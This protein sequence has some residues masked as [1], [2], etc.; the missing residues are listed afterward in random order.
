MTKRNN[1]TKAET[2]TA[3]E[4]TVFKTFIESK[5]FDEELLNSPA[6]IELVKKTAAAG[7]TPDELQKYCIQINHTFKSVIGSRPAREDKITYI[8][9]ALGTLKRKGQE[10]KQTNFEKTVIDLQDIL[11][12]LETNLEKLKFISETTLEGIEGRINLLKDDGNES[13]VQYSSL[14]AIL[15]ANNILSDYM[16][17]ISIDLE[18]AKE[19]ADRLR[20]TAKT[21]SDEKAEADDILPF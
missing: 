21:A 5:L 15:T 13:L 7:I 20:L 4:K 9:D 16:L 11:G 14:D 8:A 6:G 2:L 3:E 10:A 17:E 1:H 19:A 12:H 18:E